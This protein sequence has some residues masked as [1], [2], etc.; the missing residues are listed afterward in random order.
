M[1]RLDQSTGIEEDSKGEGRI[2]RKK[3]GRG[4]KS[5]A[6]KTSLFLA[7]TIAIKRERKNRRRSALASKRHEIQQN[8]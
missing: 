5:E 3:Q 8:E 1:Q 7:P 4:W 2:A 6:K